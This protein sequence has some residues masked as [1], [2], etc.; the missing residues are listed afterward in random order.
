MCESRRGNRRAL[1]RPLPPS[2]QIKAH[3][4]NS[5]AP[6][7]ANQQ[8]IRKQTKKGYYHTTT[9]RLLGDEAAV[10]R[11]QEPEREPLKLPRKPV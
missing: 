1:D 2:F 5:R 10:V 11:R 4:V 9:H 8:S 3:F 7:P 6:L